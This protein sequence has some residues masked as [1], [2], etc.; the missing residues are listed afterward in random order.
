MCRAAISDPESHVDPRI[1]NIAPFLVP[2]FP[3]FQQPNQMLRMHPIRKDYTFDQI[4]SFPLQIM[5]HRGKGILHLRVCRGSVDSDSW[6]RRMAYD[7]DLEKVHPWLYETYLVEDEITLGFTPGRKAAIYRFQ[8]PPQAPNS[9][10][11][12]GTDEMTST[13][14]KALLHG[15][16]AVIDQ[17]PC[18]PECRDPRRERHDPKHESRTAPGDDVGLVLC[19]GD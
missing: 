3:T 13:R 2:T 5:R 9:I 19:G 12:E 16:I 8:F 14:A 10:L 6:K 15:R 1:G 17:H 11:V 4:E 18:R 7:H